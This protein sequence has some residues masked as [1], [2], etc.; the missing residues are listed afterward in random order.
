MNPSRIMHR[1]LAVGDQTGIG[2]TKVRTSTVLAYVKP[3]AG[4]IAANEIICG[5]IARFLRLPVP[6]FGLAHTGV[7]GQ[8]TL[9]CSLSFN[10]SNED[11]PPVQADQVIALAPE[12]SAGILVFDALVGNTDRHTGN[13]A[14]D[15][16]PGNPP[17]ILVYDHSHAL[18][19]PRHGAGIA[20]LAALRDRLALNLDGKTGG[21]IHCLAEYFTDA[22]LFLRWFDRVESLPQWWI[23]GLRDRREPSTQDC[24]VVVSWT[25]G[26]S[27]FGFGLNDPSCPV[28]GDHLTLSMARSGLHRLRSRRQ[29][30]FYVIAH[31]ISVR[32]SAI[33]RNFSR[34]S[35]TRTCCELRTRINIKPARC[36]TIFHR[37][38]RSRCKPLRTEERWS[39]ALDSV[40]GRC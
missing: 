2:V 18:F 6:V 20:R 7:R 26:G 28:F 3:V 4:Y 35:K 37:E 29:L 8:P 36:F 19:G 12:L 10:F 9:F 13:L 32:Y 39:G 5:E 33:T 34:A 17:S 40:W 15:V 11:L 21:N 23:G 22:A 14:M 27:C 31:K 24:A 25:F 1:L 30:I 38:I 16:R